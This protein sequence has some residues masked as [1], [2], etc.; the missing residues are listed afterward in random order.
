MLLSTRCC[1]NTH[2]QAPSPITWNTRR[3]D[4]CTSLEC[5]RGGCPHCCPMHARH[6]IARQR[7]TLPCWKRL[8]STAEANLP[9]SAQEL[10]KQTRDIS[11]THHIELQPKHDAMEIV[12]LSCTPRRPPSRSC[13]YLQPPQAACTEP[14][15]TTVLPAPL[16]PRA[17]PASFPEPDPPLFKLRLAPSRRRTRSL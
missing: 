2:L 4:S 17:Q 6:M 16:A 3:A 1:P 7:Q 11:R 5:D 15:E 10:F 14:K 8:T 12:H 9:R 13:K